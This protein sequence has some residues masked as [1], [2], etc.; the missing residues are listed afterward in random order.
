[1]RVAVALQGDHD[2]ERRLHALPRRIRASVAATLTR[3][4][5]GLLSEVVDRKLNGEVLQRRSG[6]LAA[7]QT[8]VIEDDGFAVSVGFDDRAV[9]YGRFQEFGV[10]H[11]W[12]IEAKKARALRFSI[13]GK[14]L[15]RKRVTHPPLPARSFLRSA[16]RDFEP[17]VAPTIA[18]A[19]ANP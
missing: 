11:S 12:L 15:F 1:M 18:T 19:I 13:D 6:K 5:Y 9:P 4:G 16:L 8:L 10:P 7:S 2:V 17:L 14:T 3:L